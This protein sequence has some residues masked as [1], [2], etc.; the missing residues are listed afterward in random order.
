MRKRSLSIFVLAITLLFSVWSNVIAAA[1]CPRYLNRVGCVRHSDPQSKLVVVKSSCHHHEMA[2]M[3]MDDTQMGMDMQTEAEAASDLKTN[4]DSTNEASRT[5]RTSDLLS[6]EVAFDFPVD[7][8]AHCWS[9]S[10]PKSGAVGAAVLNP[11]K[12]VVDTHAPLTKVVLTL[13]SSLPVPITTSGH[14][15]PGNSFPRH[16]LINVFRI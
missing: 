9:H 4:T 7:A 8:C 12:Q 10:Q 15:P 16:V 2:G 13:S 11:A 1:F 3:I 6:N 5:E 14:G